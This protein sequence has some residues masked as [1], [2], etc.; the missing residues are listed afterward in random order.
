MYNGETLRHN[1]V[2]YYGNLWILKCCIIIML[3]RFISSFGPM[4][5]AYISNGFTKQ[6]YMV[7]C[8]YIGRITSLKEFLS[9]MLPID[10][11]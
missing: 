8:A 1:Y 7:L 6:Q 9:L 5:K 10:G 11:A 2:A 3:I 4:P